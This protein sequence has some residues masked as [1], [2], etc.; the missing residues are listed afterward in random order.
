MDILF[1]EAPYSGTVELCSETLKY[2]QKF[3][4]IG[5]Y[6]SVQFI[7]KLERVKKQ[8]HEIGVEWVTS[9]P[10][11][12]HVVGQILGCDSSKEFL[13]LSEQID[14]YLYVGD[15]KFHPLALVY[16]QKDCEV[17]KEVIV[18]DPVSSH[19]SLMGIEDIR[20][21][22]KRYKASLVTF[23]TANTVGILITIKPGQEHLKPSFAFEKVFPSKKFY[24][25]IDNVVSFNNLEDFNFIECWVN[26]TCPRVGFDDQEKFTKGVVN[27]SDALRAKE[28]LGKDS[29]FTRL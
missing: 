17:I 15:G 4:K 5:L 29:V 13:N 9:K 11:R 12:T 3:K 7:S 26:T 19:M 20:N 28:I 27:M 21:I 14:G 22:L 23:L 6:A 25:F 10:A 1:L 24:Y 16:A 2:I 18:N 8:L